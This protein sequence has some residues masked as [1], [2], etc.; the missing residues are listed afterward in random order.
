MESMVGKPEVLAMRDMTKAL[1]DQD[2][3]HADMVYT[4]IQW[5]FFGGPR[6]DPTKYDD[7]MPASPTLRDVMVQEGYPIPAH[8]LEILHRLRRGL[9]NL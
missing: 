5:L 4:T 8:D 9:H 2:H 7:Y 6:P 3:P 1:T